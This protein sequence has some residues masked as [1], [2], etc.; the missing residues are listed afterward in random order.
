MLEGALVGVMHDRLPFFWSQLAQAVGLG[1]QH[2][3]ESP[4]EEDEGDALVLG[5]L[6]DHFAE[7]LQDV[8]LQLA[9]TV[10]HALNDELHHTHASVLPNVLIEY[11]E[12]IN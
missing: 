1:A 2:L 5:R 3:E 11:K 10:E 8:R 4:V 12:Y 7:H 6:V 9:I